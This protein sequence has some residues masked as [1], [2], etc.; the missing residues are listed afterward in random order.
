MVDRKPHLLHVSIDWF[1]NEGVSYEIEC[2]YDELAEKRPCALWEECADRPPTEPESEEPAY[3]DWRDWAAPK[4]A[5]ESDPSVV[6]EWEAYW[7]KHAEW[8]KA[9]P[10]GPWERVNDCWIR[11]YVQEGS[12]D[13]GWTFAKDFKQEVM[14]PVPVEGKNAGEAFDDTSLVLA[15]WKESDGE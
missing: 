1:G 6:A 9:H 10:H 13:D 5:P 12:Y 15:P 11:H 8:E 3:S 4:Y 14:G 7:E 2:P